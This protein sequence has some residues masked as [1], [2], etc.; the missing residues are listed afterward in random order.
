[1]NS[2]LKPL[3]RGRFK[4][5]TLFVSGAG[6]EGRKEDLKIETKDGERLKL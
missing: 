2:N 3:F 5:K 1:M 6:R 4:T